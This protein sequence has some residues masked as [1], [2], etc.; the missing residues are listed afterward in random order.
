MDIILSS[1]LLSSF[2]VL[3]LILLLKYLIKRDIEYNG[4]EPGTPPLR[5]GD[6]SPH[7]HEYGTMLNDSLGWRCIHCGKRKVVEYDKEK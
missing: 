6:R 4:E 1:L 3:F 7:T 2:L 5:W